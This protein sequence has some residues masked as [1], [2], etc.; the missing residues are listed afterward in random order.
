[1]TSFHP[2]RKLER[3]RADDFPA[4]PAS[5]FDGF[6]SIGRPGRP[7][8]LFLE[9]AAGTGR[10]IQEQHAPCFSAGVLPGVWDAALAETRRSPA[11]RW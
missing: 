1:M 8:Q 10:R 2:H 11:R 7:A 9:K 3:R 5:H 6:G 4:V